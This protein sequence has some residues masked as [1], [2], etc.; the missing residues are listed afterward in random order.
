MKVFKW[1]FGKSKWLHKYIGLF[2]ILFLIWSAFSG[3][4]LN[5]PGLVSGISVPGW[6][7][8]DQYRTDNWNRSS[9]I[10]LL[11][12]KD[13]KRT[14]FAGGKKGI[15]KTSDGGRTFK[16]MS[17][18]YTDSLYY[19][20]VNDLLLLENDGEEQK[21][22]AASF[23]GLWVCDPAT[24]RWEKIFPLSGNVEV[25][26]VLKIGDRLVLFTPSNVWESSS[27]KSGYDFKKTGLLREGENKVEKVSLV[28][29]FFDLHGGHAWGIF[30]RILFDLVGLLIIFLSVSSFYIWYFPKKWKRKKKGGR[31]T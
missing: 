29:L 13:N 3:I 22:F 28:R 10:E 14:G 15:W 21:L 5:H 8:P 1:I 26:K 27:G 17:D 7:V 25:K 20:K 11:F 19:G 12:M 24:G 23:G 4:I 6:M 16:K 31:K 2:I 30:G 9:L 18:G